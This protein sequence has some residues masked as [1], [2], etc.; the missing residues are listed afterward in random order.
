MK[1]WPNGSQTSPCS[2]GL[3]PSA[4]DARA[5]TTWTKYRFETQ[6]DILVELGRLLAEHVTA[7]VDRIAGPELGA[8]PLAAAASMASGKPCVFVRNAKKEYGSNKQIE[9]L[10]HPGET[11]VIVEDIHDHRRAGGRGRARRSRRPG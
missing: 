7:D 10:F 1:P 6:P 4:A 9:G 5:T 11:V 3:S 8:V 2:A